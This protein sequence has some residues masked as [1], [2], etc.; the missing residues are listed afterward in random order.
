MQGAGPSVQ[1]MKDSGQR[2]LAWP[3]AARLTRGIMP[4]ISPRADGATPA[5]P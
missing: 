5:R 2:L 1:L 3:A 4:E